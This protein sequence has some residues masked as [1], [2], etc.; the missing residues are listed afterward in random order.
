MNW[1]DPSGLASKPSSGNYSPG[2]GGN[3]AQRRSATR[4]FLRGAAG[5][6]PPDLLL[7]KDPYRREDGQLVNPTNGLTPS[8]AS[9]AMMSGYLDLCGPGKRTGRRCVSWECRK[10]VTFCDAKNPTGSEWQDPGVTVSSP[11]YR[12]DKDPNCRCKRSEFFDRY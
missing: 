8:E 3:S 4:D 2:A 1:I 9:C 11:S 6:P 7:P 12:R 5:Q 10:P